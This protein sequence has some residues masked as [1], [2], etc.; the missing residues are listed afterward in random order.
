MKTDISS[1]WM[2]VASVRGKF[3]NWLFEPLEPLGWRSLSEREPSSALLS[4][5]STFYAI[6]VV[7]A[8]WANVYG[9]GDAA[10][11]LMSQFMFCSVMTVT[12]GWLTGDELDAVYTKSALASSTYTLFYF[13]THIWRPVQ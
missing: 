3:A 10:F 5:A 11:A 6:T 12:T 7:C 8:F 9:G 1:M 4:L 2:S 13:M